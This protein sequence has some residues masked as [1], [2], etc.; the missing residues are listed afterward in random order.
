MSFAVMMPSVALLQTVTASSAIIPA[1]SAAADCQ[2]FN[3]LVGE[4]K[5]VYGKYVLRIS[6][7]DVIRYKVLVAL[8]YVPCSRESLQFPAGTWRKICGTSIPE[9]MTKNALRWSYSG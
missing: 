6:E 8:P 2:T 4:L 3:G 1:N 9:I 5:V 7:P